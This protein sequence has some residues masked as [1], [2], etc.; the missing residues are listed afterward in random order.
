M[1]RAARM[2]DEGEWFLLA[3]FRERCGSDAAARK[4]FLDWLA[5]RDAERTAATFRMSKGRS[6]WAVEWPV[7]GCW[8]RFRLAGGCM[9]GRIIDPAD[10]AMVLGENRDAIDVSGLERPVVE[11]GLAADD[12][13]IRQEDFPGEADR[14]LVR[15]SCRRSAN[16]RPAGQ[17][18]ACGCSMSLGSFR[19]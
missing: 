7:K 11:L 12:E 19:L 18:D 17:R 2:V 9:A 8:R 15:R 6:P 3:V 14:P 5:R 10:T 16:R 4:A 1:P 13:C